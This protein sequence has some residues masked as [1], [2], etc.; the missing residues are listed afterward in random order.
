MSG[1]EVLVDAETAGPDGSGV[2][3]GTV[4][5]GIGVGVGTVRTRMGLRRIGIG[6]GG[7]RTWKIR[8]DRIWISIM[9][10]IHRQVYRA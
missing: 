4:G 7:G 2:G 5:A 10:C 8:L 9:N 1:V 3:L 6:M